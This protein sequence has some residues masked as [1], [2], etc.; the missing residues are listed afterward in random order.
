M[1]PKGRRK[2]GFQPHSSDCRIGKRQALGVDIL[3]IVRGNDHINRGIAQA[4]NH[5][6]TVVFTTQ[7]RGETEKSPVLAN[8]VLIQRQIMDG[9]R[10]CR[11]YVPVLGPANRFSRQ[12]SRNL[13]RVV[14]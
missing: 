11:F 4:F 3:W 6:L 2:Q 10:R 12:R 1:K 14:V 5:R 8:V 13:G 7:M 9:N